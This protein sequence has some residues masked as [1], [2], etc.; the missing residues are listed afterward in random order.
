[1]SCIE[2]YHPHTRGLISNVDSLVNHYYN[3]M[4][5]KGST[6]D[7]WGTL[8]EIHTTNVTVFHSAEQTV[9]FYSNMI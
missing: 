7:P 8:I 6:I 2:W 4:N 9:I 3:N 1:M 5:N